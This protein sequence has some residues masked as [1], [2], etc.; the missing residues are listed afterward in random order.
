[1]H[2]FRVFSGCLY[3]YS[4]VPCAKNI[5]TIVL[6]P[7][8]SRRTDYAY[9]LTELYMIGGSNSSQPSPLHQPDHFP[10][11]SLLQSKKALKL[12]SF[13]SVPLSFGMCLMKWWLYLQLVLF[14]TL[15]LK[16][17]AWFI[18]VQS[19][20]MIRISECLKA[21]WTLEGYSYMSNSSCVSVL[22]ASHTLPRWHSQ[23]VHRSIQSYSL[24]PVI[25]QCLAAGKHI[26]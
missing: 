21:L 16:V 17:Q 14:S 1:M 11:L 19:L 5:W 18:S 23:D 22:N 10:Y 12:S 8:L 9:C 2:T 6:G 24:T 4:L 26:W 20:W 7:L 13:P 15:L 25:Y 3:S